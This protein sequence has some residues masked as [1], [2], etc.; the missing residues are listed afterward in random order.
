MRSSSPLRL[1]LLLSA[2]AG[3]KPGEDS[4]A[5]SGEACAE[6]ALAEDPLCASWLLNEDEEAAVIETEGPVLVR[7]QSATLLEREG[8]RFVRVRASGVPDYAFTLSGEQLEALESRPLAYADFRDGRPTVAVGETVAFGQDI[9]YDS[10]GCSGDEGFGYWP[11]GP[12]CPEDVAHE[13]LFPVEVEQADQP[14]YTQI[15]AMGLFVDGVAMFNWSDGQSHDN[16]GVWHNLAAKFE[17]YDADLCGGHAQQEGMYHLHFAA[18]CLGAQLGDD[19]SAHSPVY[20]FVAD[21]VP[22]Y[23][24]W[25][26]AGERA[27]SCWRARDYDDPADPLGCGGTGERSCLL[28]DPLDP[29]QGT[30]EAEV[31]GPRT[32]EE[33]TSLSSNIFVVASGYYFEDWVYDADCTDGG[34]ARMD[35]HNGHEHDGLG[36]HYHMTETFPY[37]AGPIFYGELR[38]GALLECSDEPASGPAGGGPPPG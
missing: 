27:E 19:G 21:G 15:D 32:D 12:A 1:L 2:C 17:I 3:D 8:A 25:V 28:V 16:A 36:Y 26:A 11:P 9:G 31:A 29:S 23:G 20:G 22:L 13:A 5:G 33:V 4:G 18:D 24:P 30:V 38:D 35:S 7:V 10:V 37:F 14:C 6:S 34:L